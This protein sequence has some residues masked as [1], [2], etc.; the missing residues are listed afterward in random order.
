MIFQSGQAASGGST[1]FRTRVRLRS[2]LTMTP[3]AS[4]H[5]AAGSTTSAYGLVSVSANTSWVMTSSAAS[6]P[7]MTVPR[8]ATD[9]T[10]FVQ[11]TQHALISPAAI[12]SNISTVPRPNPSA[13][14]VPGGSPH[15]CSTNA[16]SASTSTDRCPGRPGPM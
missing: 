8:L 3:S 9:A 2:E 11:I 12:R 14:M 4:A 6:R 13:R 1:A 5:I 15:R 10:G 16:R 7:A